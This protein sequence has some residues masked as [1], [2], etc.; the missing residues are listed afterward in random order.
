MTFT[1]TFNGE[2]DVY[3]G[4][5]DARQTTSVSDVQID[6]SF[7][8][9]IKP[10]PSHGNPII[11]IQSEEGTDVLLELYDMNGRLMALNR[12][13]RLHSKEKFV[14]EWFD[15]DGPLTTGIFYVKASTKNHG[16]RLA[17][18]LVIAE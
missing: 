3:Y 2:Q 6:D 8:L 10:N 5:I 4:F 11:A 16:H 13:D 9:M 12:T 1:G 7:Q 14:N 15:L 18:I 17:R